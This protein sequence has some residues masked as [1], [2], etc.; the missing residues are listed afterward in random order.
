[1]LDTRRSRLLQERGFQQID[2]DLDVSTPRQRD[3]DIDPQ[4]PK[5]KPAPLTDESLIDKLIAEG[6]GIELV[7]VNPDKRIDTN[8]DDTATQFDTK[9]GTDTPRPNPYELRI[10]NNFENQF[11]QANT[12]I[13][14][15]FNEISTTRQLTPE[16]LVALRDA[17]AQK[18]NVANA[19]ATG[20]YGVI[21]DGNLRSL[22]ESAEHSQ[23]FNEADVV[24]QA[25]GIDIDN[26]HYKE[27]EKIIKEAAI[28]SSPPSY[29]D[30]Q[31]RA[32]L[33]RS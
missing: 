11:R 22:M 1:M 7:E 29:T 20:D 13:D 14:R 30:A 18:I 10:L 26:P 23:V 33:P 15:V 17:F 16:N 8:I 6:G 4:Q 25:G 28:R 32:V 9:F 27:L 2:S 5:P 24:L 31:K 21:Q 12:V 19:Y 3:V